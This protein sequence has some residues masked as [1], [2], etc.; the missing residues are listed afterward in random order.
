MLA[1]DREP[2][3]QLVAG[4]FCG[5]TSSR[6][7]YQVSERVTKVLSDVGGVVDVVVGFDWYVVAVF[8][9]APEEFA[10]HLDALVLGGWFG[11][12]FGHVQMV[13]SRDGWVVVVGLEFWVFADC[14]SWSC[15]WKVRQIFPGE[16][17]R[18]MAI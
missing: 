9:F 17:R 10:E 4:L 16:L 3:L 13:K 12:L 11:R 8:A 15:L 7:H 18:S 1:S 5:A 2:P 6:R 14:E